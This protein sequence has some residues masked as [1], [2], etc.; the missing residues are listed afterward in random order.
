M[1]Y[2]TCSFILT[3]GT[4]CESPALKD[5]DFCYFHHRDRQRKENLQQARELKCSDQF[6]KYPMQ[7]ELLN[8][9]IIES[10]DI[11]S[12]DDGPSIQ[13]AVTNIV[14]AVLSGHVSDKRA[15]L[16]LFGCQ[17]AVTNLSHTNVTISQFE[18]DKAATTDANPIPP[19]LTT[20]PQPAGYLEQ[21]AAA[22]KLID[23]AQK[24][25][26]GVSEARPAPASAPAAKEIGTRSA[27]PSAL[28]TGNR[29]LE[30]AFERASPQIRQ[31]D[32]F[33]SRGEGGTKKTPAPPSTLETRKE[34]LETATRETRNVQRETSRDTI[35]VLRNPGPNSKTFAE[36][37]KL[38]DALYKGTI[39]AEEFKKEQKK[40]QRNGSSSG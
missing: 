30:T 1:S 2:P 27:Q 12:L 6:Y 36:H 8:P 24:L 3:R 26:N 39:A 32:E 14:R 22:R 4:L 25:H 23:Q 31:N 16:A 11:P 33:S 40:E 28:D 15:G 38:A 17:I 13:V 10:L 19:Y 29:K 37:V 20:K 9:E 7:Q 34:K 35:R 5:N 21:L 18:A